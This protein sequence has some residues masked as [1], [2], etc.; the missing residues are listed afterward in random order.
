MT[1]SFHIPSPTAATAAAAATT[2]YYIGA[3]AHFMSWCFWRT[4]LTDF[5][6][7]IDI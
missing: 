4:F 2:F 1:A 5:E 6:T 7:F 3:F